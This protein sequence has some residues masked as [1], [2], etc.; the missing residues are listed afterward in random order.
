MLR[1]HTRFCRL[2]YR[3]DHQLSRGCIAKNENLQPTNLSSMRSGIK[4]VRL[5]TFP[6][7]QKWTLQKSAHLD[8][9]IPSDSCKHLYLDC[10]ASKAR[11]R[12]GAD[13]N[14][15]FWPCLCDR[16]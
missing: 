16:P 1:N 15:I 3:I 6:S 8:C 5:F 11:I 10:A 12:F 7:L 14:N 2:S 9:S 13:S 4:Y